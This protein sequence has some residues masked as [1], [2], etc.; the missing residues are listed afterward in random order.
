MDIILFLVWFWVFMGLIAVLVVLGVRTN[1]FVELIS[2]LRRVPVVWMIKKAGINEKV[3]PKKVVYGFAFFDNKETGGEIAYPIWVYS[4][5]KTREAIAFED[6]AYPINFEFMRWALK[7]KKRGFPDYTSMEVAY[8]VKQI[9]A[10]MPELKNMRWDRPIAIKDEETGKVRRYKRM[11]EFLQEEFITRG[12]N[13]WF[14]AVDELREV[15]E[16]KLDELVDDTV[17][18]LFNNMRN[19]ATHNAS[20]AVYEDIIKT[21]QVKEKHDAYNVE[22][23]LSKFI[24]THWVEIGIMLF[25]VFLGLAV[26]V[27]FGGFSKLLPA[28]QNVVVSTTTTTLPPIVIGA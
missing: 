17:I 13:P 6:M 9:F 10:E 14:A 12:G 23:G 3:C 22:G 26:F 4:T 8:F 24:K 15:K 5:G 7:A 1:V 27:M 2:L 18:D 11:I 16:K 20:A 21:A 25:L 19:F 28:V